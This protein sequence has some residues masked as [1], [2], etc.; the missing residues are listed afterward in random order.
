MNY[1][2]ASGSNPFEEMTKI[3]D[4][5]YLALM[6]KHIELNEKK[7]NKAPDV[8]DLETVVYSMQEDFERISK[9]HKTYMSFNKH[10]GRGAKPSEA[11]SKEFND[12]IASMKSS[13]MGQIVTDISRNSNGVEK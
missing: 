12:L 13:T 7:R 10:I 5:M 3:I 9:T 4:D 6:K 8:S 2:N 11:S 1:E